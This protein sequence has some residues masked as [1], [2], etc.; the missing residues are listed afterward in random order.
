MIV[1]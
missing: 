1:R